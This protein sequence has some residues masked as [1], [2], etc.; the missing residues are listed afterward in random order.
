[1]GDGKNAKRSAPSQLTSAEF[2]RLSS[3]KKLALIAIRRA[4]LSSRVAVAA[5]RSRHI[6][7]T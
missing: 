6:D 4:Q 7:R 1:M 2:A 5:V 3:S